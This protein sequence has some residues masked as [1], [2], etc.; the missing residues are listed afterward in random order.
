MPIKGSM[1]MDT[2]EFDRGIQ[3]LIKQFS[4]EQ[5]VAELEVLA[6]QL[7]KKA[8]DAPIPSST[9][10]L[11]N[12]A[13]VNVYPKQGE[14]VFGFGAGYAAFQ[15]QPERKGGVVVIK[16]RVKKF[17][18][19]PITAKAKKHRIGNNPANEGLEPEVDY[20]IR[21]SASIPIKPY[22][23][24]LGPNHYFSQTLRDNG[25]WALAAFAKYLARKLQSSQRG[26]K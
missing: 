16:P 19:I 12:S 21:R 26:E 7:L 22:G 18:F 4:K 20:V 11:A 1:T 23:S 17:L 25:K 3:K 15:D 10:N 2:R 9:R 8:I 24:A 14:V 13:A 6:D 5:V